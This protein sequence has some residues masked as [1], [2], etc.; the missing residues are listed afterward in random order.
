MRLL[1]IC[2]ELRL[3]GSELGKRRIGIGLLLALAART[4]IP[5]I[6][7]VV[8]TVL[9]VARRMIPAAPL[10]SATL[11]AAFLLI[12]TFL[13]PLLAILAEGGP[14][15]AAPLA[16]RF[17]S[18]LPRIAGSLTLSRAN[19]PRWTAPVPALVGLRGL[20]SGCRRLSVRG[21]CAIGRR[22]C[23]IAMLAMGGTARTAALLAAAARSPD[24]DELRFGR[25]GGALRRSICRRPVCR[26]AVCRRLINRRSVCR[27]GRDLGR[28][29]NCGRF[30]FRFGRGTYR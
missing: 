8:A 17:G 10:L 21:D 4:R 14:L 11:L 20:C 22:L 18:P 3:E 9:L 25:R 13:T 12:A 6:L 24:L 26:R 23:P 7:G 30:R 15:A 27:R 5:A 28:F 1:C 29:R 19:L 16:T 2:L